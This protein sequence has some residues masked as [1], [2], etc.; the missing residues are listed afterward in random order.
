MEHYAV[1]NSDS[2]QGNIIKKMKST[3]RNKLPFQYLKLQHE[4]LNNLRSENS[5]LL[6]YITSMH[7]KNNESMRELRILRTKLLEKTFNEKANIEKILKNITVCEQCQVT[8]SLFDRSEENYLS[9]KYSPTKFSSY[10]PPK[11][12]ETANAG[13]ISAM[14][15]HRLNAKTLIAES[16][17]KVSSTK[18]IAACIAAAKAT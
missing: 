16:A 9:K 17:T 11:L 14:K 7:K 5:K 13:N 2:L 3:P 6:G 4:Q 10:S 8:H 15:L 12:S 1:P 18:K